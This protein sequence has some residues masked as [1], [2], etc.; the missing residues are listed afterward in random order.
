MAVRIPG[1]DWWSDL[2]FVHDTGASCMTLYQEDIDTM[3]GPFHPG[4]M[5]Q[6]IPQ[7]PVLGTAVCAAW[8]DSSNT[9]NLYRLEVAVLDKH[10]RRITPWARVPCILNPGRAPVNT[11]DTNR[12]DGPLLHYLL[13]VFSTPDNTGKITAATSRARYALA[14]SVPENERRVDFGNATYVDTIKKATGDRLA[15]A[16]RDMQDIHQKEFNRVDNLN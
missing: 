2:Q 6:P 14:N 4:V 1:V 16:Y 11:D 13:Y 12:L 9:Y 5:G 10:K 15:R 8:N 7:L 3:L